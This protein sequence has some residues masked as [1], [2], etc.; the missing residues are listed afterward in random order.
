MYCCDPLLCTFH[1]CI[2]H[3]CVYIDRVAVKNHSPKQVMKQ[4]F[5]GV[6]HVGL[7]DLNLL[8]CSVALVHVYRV[9]GRSYSHILKTKMS[10]SYHRGTT[11]HSGDNPFA[12]TS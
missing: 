3:N 8:L 7:Y 12:L 1:S 10:T 5:L 11:A 6:H 9:E 2:L 4:T